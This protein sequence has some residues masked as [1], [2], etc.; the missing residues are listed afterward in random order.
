MNIKR[1]I[2]SL[3]ILKL[4]YLLTLFFAQSS[5]AAFCQPNSCPA[6]LECREG[7]ADFACMYRYPCT[8]D[9]CP[10]DQLCIST[11][12][13]INDY[14]CVLPNYPCTADACP[15][16]QRCISTGIGVNDF[17][18]VLPNYP[19]TADA[20]P[21]DQICISTGSGIND[22]RCEPPLVVI[23]VDEPNPV[24]G[25]TTVPTQDTSPVDAIKGPTNATFNALNPLNI[26]AGRPGQSAR[27]P[28][29]TVLQ[30]PGG[31]I[32]RALAFAFPIAGMILFLMIVWGGFEMVTGATNAKSMDAGKQRI[33]AAVIGF[34]LL[35]TSYWLMQIIGTIFGLAI[36]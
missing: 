20:C 22:Y 19:C 15:R 31:V 10:R 34:I 21:R 35:F 23:P 5:F 32:S 17:Q 8:A 16:G 26:A 9:A 25:G 27:S 30:T 24:D 4:M 6:H 12:S 14:R 33:T 29:F 1:K 13:G 11:G 36:L 2:L 28:F 3:I 18:C 7:T